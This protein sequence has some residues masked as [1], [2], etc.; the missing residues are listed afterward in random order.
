MLKDY[1]SDLTLT[2]VTNTTNDYGIE[3]AAETNT[4]IKGLI[5]KASSKEIEI[6]MA[7]NIDVDYKA[8][9]EV[10]TTTQSITKNDLINGYRVVSD[11]KNTI[12]RNLHFKISLKEVI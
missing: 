7:R 9:V 6:A 2:K 4:T 10:T 8:Y 3:V 5:N 1:Y 12:G 11:P